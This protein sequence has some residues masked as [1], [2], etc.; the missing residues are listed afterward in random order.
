V[1]QP[2]LHAGHVHC[3]V[4]GK[5]LLH[6]AHLG[7]GGKRG[8]RGWGGR[9][10]GRRTP[11]PLQNASASPGPSAL[12]VAPA[13]CTRQHDPLPCPGLP[14]RP[15]P[16]PLPPCGCCAARPASPAPPRRS[17]G[18]ARGAGMVRGKA[19]G[20]T[21]P[22]DLAS[23]GGACASSTRQRGTHLLQQRHAPR[24]PAGARPGHQGA[25]CRSSPLLAL[26]RRGK[27]RLHHPL[28]R[29]LVVR[30]AEGVC[31]WGGGCGGGRGGGVDAG[32]GARQP[33]GGW[34]NGQAGGM[35]S[36]S[37][38]ARPGQPR[39]QQPVPPRPL[40]QLLAP[41]APGPADSSRP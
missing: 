3:A 19:P 6:G 36:A 30:Q 39:H 24:Q 1:R 5:H 18:P 11:L 8:G 38:P 26:G 2:Q 7:A 17:A 31:V 27:Q 13:P 12:S 4:R 10:P 25:T 9:C 21:G 28:V 37:R 14:C 40:Q 35:A 34:P 20:R 15:P 32:K 23:G 22:H 16:A 29:L 41:L 33:R